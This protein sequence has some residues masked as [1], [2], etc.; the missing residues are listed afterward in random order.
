MS[1][2]QQFRLSRVSHDGYLMRSQ[3]DYPTMPTML[4]H[5]V[6]ERMMLYGL[7]K[8]LQKRG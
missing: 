5:I 3:F 7:L 4:S 2:S 1:I 8:S 6:D